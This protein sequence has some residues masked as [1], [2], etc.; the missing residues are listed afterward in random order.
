[1]IDIVCTQRI[2]PGMEERVERLLQEAEKETLAHDKGCERYEWYRGSDPNTYVLIERWSDREAVQA[3]LRSAHMERI[4]K[5]LADLV[6]EKFS[7]S[8]LTRLA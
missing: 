7:V 1:M 5:E 4:L 8:R 6:P 2:N 3:H